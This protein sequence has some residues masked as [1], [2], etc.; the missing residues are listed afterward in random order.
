MNKTFD[1]TENETLASLALVKPCLAAMGGK[2]P[3]DLEDDEYT[4]V[5]ITVL[6]DA[7][8]NRHE[9]AGTFGALMEKSI[10]SEYDKNEWVLTTAAWVWLDTIWDKAAAA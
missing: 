4:W 10:V 3:A 1:L 7:G 5:D 2:R 9:A 6:T 8:W